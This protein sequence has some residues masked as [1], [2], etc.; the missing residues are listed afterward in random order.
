MPERIIITGGSGQLA[1][2]IR[3]R[4][5]ASGDMRFIFLDK[6]QCDICNPSQMRDIFEKHRC[7]VLINCA[8]YT[9]VDAAEA[10]KEAAYAIN[11]EGVKNLSLL[12]SELGFYLIHISTDYVFDGQSNR[13]YTERDP[14]NPVNTYGG[15]KL[16]GE[17]HMHKIL[18]KGLI[19]RTGWLYFEN[20]PNFVSTMMRLGKEREEIGV[21]FD[22]V[23]TP[24]YA[25]DLAAF[26]LHTIDAPKEEGVASVHYSNEGVAS[27]YDFAKETMRLASLACRVKPILSHQYPAPAPRPVYSVLDK[28]KA[29]SLFEINIPYWRDSLEI[30]IQ[31][32][33]G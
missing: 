2:A 32:Q 22:Q 23:G 29:K 25:G 24:T 33:R 4:V 6:E 1:S 12:S 16:A 19:I 14:L 5:D 21:V 27:W 8:A 11:A 7:N 20:H 17:N 31:K 26:I 15:S 30:C 3:E 9:K 10:E 18:Q 13:P 28:Q